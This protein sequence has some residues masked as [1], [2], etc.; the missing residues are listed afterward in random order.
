[1]W[2]PQADSTPKTKGAD[3]VTIDPVTLEKV[4]ARLQGWMNATSEMPRDEFIKLF[5]QRK[6]KTH[7]DAGCWQRVQ[8]IARK[9]NLLTKEVCLYPARDAKG[10]CDDGIRVQ[11]LGQEHHHRKGRFSSKPTTPVRCGSRS[12]ARTTTAPS[13]IGSAHD[14]CPMKSARNA[15]AARWNSR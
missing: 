12:T 7:G 4:K 6:G 9:C 10:F 14:G 15:Q 8:D 5:I 11:G 13:C 3:E 2:D 1:M